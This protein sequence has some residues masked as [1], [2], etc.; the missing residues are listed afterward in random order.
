[1]LYRISSHNLLV[2]GN[3]LKDSSVNNRLSDMKSKI[4][5]CNKRPE[6][7]VLEQ[8]EFETSQSIADMT[9]NSDLCEIKK[10]EDQMKLNSIDSYTMI[11][12]LQPDMNKENKCVEV[13]SKYLKR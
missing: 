6:M 12:K 3:T 2:N 1:M 11:P 10:T 8:K 7:R 13:S 5:S 4:E 9:W